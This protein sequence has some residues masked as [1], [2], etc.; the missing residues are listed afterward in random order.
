MLPIA[1]ADVAH[2]IIS[3]D[4]IDLKTLSSTYFNVCIIILRQAT[5]AVGS[6]AP[7]ASRA[8]M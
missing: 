8:W 1:M 4:L 6:P 5:T 3:F 2:L 7:A